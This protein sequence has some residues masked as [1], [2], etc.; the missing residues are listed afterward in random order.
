MA[1]WIGQARGLLDL[2]PWVTQLLHK[3]LSKSLLGPGHQSALPLW[4]LGAPIEA[5]DVGRGEW[6]RVH[7]YL[8]VKGQGKLEGVPELMWWSVSA[9]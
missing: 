8:K 1:G 9:K 5:Q 2:T 7:F 6:P 4:I 3:H